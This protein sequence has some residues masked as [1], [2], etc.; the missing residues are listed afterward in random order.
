MKETTTIKV[1]KDTSRLLEDLRAKM[2]VKNLDE[3][4]QRLIVEWRMKMLDEAFGL[5]RG[6]VRP[7][8]EED[9]GEDRT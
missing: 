5:D 7:F 6:R 3:V 9:R 4:I 2:K 8:T 1:L